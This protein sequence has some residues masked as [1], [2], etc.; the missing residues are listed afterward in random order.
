[1]WLGVRPK[2][3]SYGIEFSEFVTTRAGDATQI[4]RE[5]IEAGADRVVAVGG[6]GT[7]NEVLNGYLDTDG[8]PVNPDAILGLLPS[9]TGSDFQ[10]SLGFKTTGDSIEAVCTGTTRS[11]DALQISLLTRDNV[12]KKRFGINVVTF[13]LGGETARLVNDWRDRVPAWIGGQ[14]RFLAA[15]IGALS[16]YE[17][18]DVT[19]RLNGQQEIRVF[20]NLI[21]VGSG[22]FA[23]GGMMLLPEAKIDDGR[24][25]VMVT[26]NI[27]RSGIILELR[28]IRQGGHLK[29]SKV[30]TFQAREVT[31]ESRRPLALDVDGEMIGFSPVRVR[32]LPS[33][34]RFAV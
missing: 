3:K 19:V 2:I 18:T 9:G 33:V 17:N 6:D 15:A 22:R 24:L 21:V 27:S 5:A 12:E 20:S 23:G 14:A 32:V 4:T 16:N 26:N 11:I 31:V 10:R 28:R 30:S 29:N 13:G 34:V 7:L 8:R 25:E 1:M